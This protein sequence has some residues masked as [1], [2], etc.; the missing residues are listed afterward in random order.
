[1]TQVT[2]T[3]A[4][5]IFSNGARAADT[6]ENSYPPGTYE[7]CVW[8]QGYQIKHGSQKPRTRFDRISAIQ[9]MFEK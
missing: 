9:M 5:Q 4:Q 1:M 6:C 7:H 8:N 3:E 2:S